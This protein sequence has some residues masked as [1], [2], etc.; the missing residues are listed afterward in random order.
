MRLARHLLYV[1]TNRPCAEQ[2]EQLAQEA[3]LIRKTAG[4]CLVAIV[5]HHDGPWSAAHRQALA[6]ARDRHGIDVAHMNWAATTAF[7]RAVVDGVDAPAEERERLFALLRPSAV[8]YGAGPNKA[9]LLAA[10]AGARVLHRRDSDV[11]VDERPDLGPVYPCVLETKA[12]D[13]RVVDLGLEVQSGALADD[14]VVAFVGTDAFGSAVHDRRDLLTVDARHIV[15]IELL[16]SPDAS[17]EA[18][19]QETAQYLIAAPDLRYDRDFFEEDVNARTCVGSACV[20]DIFLELPE[21]PIHRTLGS[22][23][24]GRNALR[25]LGRPIIYHSRKVRH[26]YEAARAEQSDLGAVVDYACRDLRHMIIWPVLVAHHRTLRARPGD[27][28]DAAGRLDTKAYTASLFAAL[29]ASMPIMTGMPK[30]FAAI[31]RTASD[32]TDDAARRE[33]LRAVAEAVEHGPNFVADVAQ[34]LRDYAFLIGHWPALIASARRTGPDS[35][36]L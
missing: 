23:Y 7:L 30:A 15:E 8:A 25:F 22:D 31:Y 10:A 3:L 1:P 28:L 17:R 16:A 33:R 32:E 11:R 26:R 9:A 14:D 19:M 20:A 18:L 27:F 29:E 36:M 2:I 5:E 35:V 34:G 24:L 6:A 21:M 13:A 12:I 4:S